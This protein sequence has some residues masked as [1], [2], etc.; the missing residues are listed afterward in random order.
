MV[1]WKSLKF[2]YPWPLYLHSPLR[3]KKIFCTSKF[4][5]IIVIEGLYFEM[6]TF[7]FIKTAGCTCF[8]WPVNSL[9]CKVTSIQRLSTPNFR[10]FSSFFRCSLTYLVF[11]HLCK[12]V[13]RSFVVNKGF[14]VKV[15]KWQF[16]KIVHFP[17]VVYHLLFTRFDWFPGK[18][19]LVYLLI[20]WWPIQLLRSMQ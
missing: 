19:F 14:N 12:V 11:D 5:D 8:S 20:I 7:I 17:C 2:Q 3:A 4:F 6:Q 18:W 13:L 16:L 9:F 15:L 1:S 10:Y